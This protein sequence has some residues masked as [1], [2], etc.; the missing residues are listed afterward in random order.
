MANIG[1]EIVKVRDLSKYTIVEVDNLDNILKDDKFVRI[2]SELKKK[3]FKKVALNLEAIDN[4]EYIKNE[5][6][7]TTEESLSIKKITIYSFL[8]SFFYI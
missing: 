1:S 5:I 4:D 3:S 7:K 8:N 2:N 6:I